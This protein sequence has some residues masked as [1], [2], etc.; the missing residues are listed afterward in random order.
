MKFDFPP[1]AD[2]ELDEAVRYYEGCQP[3]LSA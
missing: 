3:G 2:E 1:D